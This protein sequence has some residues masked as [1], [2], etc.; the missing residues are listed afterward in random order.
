MLW[1]FYRTTVASSGSKLFE[2][3]RNESITLYGEQRCGGEVKNTLWGR[4]GVG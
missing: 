1:S 4:G 2:P 3:A